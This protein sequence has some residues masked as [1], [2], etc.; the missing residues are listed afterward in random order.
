MFRYAALPAGCF[1]TLFGILGLIPPLHENWPSDE[2]HM[3]VRN[4]RGFL[5][6]TFPNNLPLSLIYLGVGFW[7]L[8][9]FRTS[10]S[11]ALFLWTMVA[12]F[13]TLAIAGLLPGI[14]SIAGVIPTFGA[15]ALLHVATVAVALPAALAIQRERKTAGPA[16]PEPA[17]GTG[18]VSIASIGGVPAHVLLAAF[19]LVFLVAALATDLA[20]WW[21]TLDWYADYGMFWA[22]ASVWLISAGLG[23]AL[24]ASVAGLVDVR[25]APAAWRRDLLLVHG[26]GCVAV[27]ALAGVNLSLRIAE[28]DPRVIP[29]GIILSL[30]TAV[31]L[32]FCGW[33]AGHLLHRDVMR[34]EDDGDS[35]ATPQPTSAE[36]ASERSPQ[37]PADGQ[38]GR[39]TSTWE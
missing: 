12:L 37:R 33:Y 29:W 7:G 35:S 5:F 9:S 31:V 16:S 18:A 22:T 28:H 39:G 38:R 15:T 32:I 11:A 3:A 23:S 27:M 6:S 17:L 1:Y 24:I 19:P 8:L 21:T 10:R 4:A 34:V 26:A 14:N 25:S 36:T 2:P 20:H 13:G 30:L